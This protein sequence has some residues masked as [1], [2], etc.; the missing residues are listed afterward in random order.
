MDLV[1]P[2]TQLVVVITS[3]LNTQDECQLGV[4]KALSIVDS[5]KSI[6]Y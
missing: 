3:E 4:E 2:D 6:T 5:I 1:V